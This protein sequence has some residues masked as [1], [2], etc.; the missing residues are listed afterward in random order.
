MGRLKI[1]IQN[2]PG[3]ER[4]LKMERGKKALALGTMKINIIEWG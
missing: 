1:K 3:K 2:M 4:A